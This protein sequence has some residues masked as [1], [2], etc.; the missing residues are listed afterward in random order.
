MKRNLKKQEKH[1]FLFPSIKLFY[2]K[3]DQ[4][5]VSNGF[6]ETIELLN[7]IMCGS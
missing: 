1:L 5:I 2:I 7:K 4:V 6:E 3:K